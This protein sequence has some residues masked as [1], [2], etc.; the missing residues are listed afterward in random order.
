MENNVSNRMKRRGNKKILDQKHKNLPKKALENG[1][2]IGRNSEIR[3]R[4]LGVGK[5]HDKCNV[6]YIDV[7]MST[8]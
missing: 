2:G 7:E 4:S 3:R 6:S 1:T 5:G 8:E